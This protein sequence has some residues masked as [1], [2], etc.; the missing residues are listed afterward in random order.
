MDLSRMLANGNGQVSAP[1]DSRRVQLQSTDDGTAY[2]K[3]EPVNTRT[4]GIT[5]FR[6]HKADAP[7]RPRGSPAKKDQKHVV[8]QLIDQE[9]PRIQARLP[10]RVMIS[11]HDNTDSIITTVKNFYGLYDYGVS[12]E[13][14]EG[15]SIIAAYDNFENDMTVYVRT[16]MQ[17]Q[18][19]GG[20]VRS[21][22]SP[23]KPML[24]APFEAR[25]HHG[26]VYSPSRHAA[27]SA[28]VRSMSPASE[29]GRRSMSTASKGRSLKLK[30]KDESVLGDADGN[31]SDDGANASV[32]SSRRSK[33]EQLNA[34]ISTDNIVEGG[35]RKRA[36]ESSELP[37]FV[38]PQMP[39]SASISSISPQRRSG[40]PY[41]GS[42]HA[43]SNQQNF[44][45]T[46]PMPS[47][48]NGT[49]L[50]YGQPNMH[51]G[52]Y[53]AFYQQPRP[54]RSRVSGAS[55]TNRLSTGGIMP[56]PDPTV[57]S[58]ISDE[59]VALQLMRLGDASNFSYGRT[60]TS[61]VDDALSGKAEAPSSD[62][63]DEHD[64]WSK[65]D[66]P[67]RKKQRVMH[68]YSSEAS[69]GDE[70]EDG[71]DESFKTDGDIAM[72]D[73]PRSGKQKTKGPDHGKQSKPRLGSFSKPKSKSA[74]VPKGPM[75]PA[76]MAP[77]SRKASIASSS[78]PLGP[79]EEDLSSKPRCQRC[80][81]SKKG[82][83]RQRPCGRCKDAGI[84]IEGCVSED[85][86]NGRKGR[87]GRH[88]GVPVKK[89]DEFVL[90]QNAMPMPGVPNG[91]YFL[92]PAP[93][94]KSKKRKR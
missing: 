90:P 55:S 80:R 69:S 22:A 64:G 52:G 79:D 48:Q 25:S 37:L 50:T 3:Q 77:H 18:T 81:K 41:A 91:G 49:A 23:K 2:I 89:E 46:Q 54:M 27:R 19:N 21:A 87:Y 85:E 58:A 6:S 73:V 65:K 59:D 34:E 62:E 56:T 11:A 45:Y 93:I 30:S 39:I 1:T 74:T 57:G 16:V 13:N 38:P 71:R 60:S 40:P 20:S 29:L 47:P 17:S 43:F 44:T 67:R 76:S 28:G 8:F 36:F 9:D 92:A 10:M 88:M 5:G 63:D 86:G 24:G 7:P 66:G 32:T 75:S 82:C 31:S 42:P 61:T 70:Y 78:N 12:F 26:S 51:S 14:K 4:N 94:D 83:D 68:D 72:Q 15:I 84:G 33:T 53:S 35:R